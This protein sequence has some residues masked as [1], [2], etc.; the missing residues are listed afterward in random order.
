MKWAAIKAHIT[1]KVLDKSYSDLRERANIDLDFLLLTVAAALICAF[2][3]EM[4][5]AS[6]IV[7]AMVISPLL[8]PVICVGAA[9]YKVDW[10]TCRRAVGTFV[11]G[12][13]AAVAASVLMNVLYST[14]ARSEIIDRLGAAELDYFFVAFFSGLA[15]TYAYFSPKMHEAIAGIAISVALIPPVVMLG[16]GLAEHDGGL[17]VTSGKIMLSNVFGIYAGSFIMV[18]ALHW[19]AG[20]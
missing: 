7:G 16:F 13:L 4:N 17:I 20:K 1:R 2:G 11:I 19:I 3:F 5:S 6:V 12:F 8:Y 9:T 10:P 15:G 14:A 18:A